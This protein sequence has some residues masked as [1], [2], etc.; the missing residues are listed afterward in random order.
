MWIET[1]NFI[2]LIEWILVTA[3][4]AFKNIEQHNKYKIVLIFHLYFNK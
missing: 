1:L 4:K 3:L 2:Y